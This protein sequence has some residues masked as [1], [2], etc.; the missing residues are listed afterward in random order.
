MPEPQKPG[1][2]TPSWANVADLIRRVG[3]PMVLVAATMVYMG[4]LQTTKLDAHIEES[5][6]TLKVARAQ[7]DVLWQMASSS[8]R[9][10]INT[11]KLAQ[12][13][14]LDCVIVLPRDK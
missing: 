9:S 7:L 10:C 1:S 4:W 12:T 13:D 2:M 14:P 5:H 6:E 8:Q 3:M 11:A